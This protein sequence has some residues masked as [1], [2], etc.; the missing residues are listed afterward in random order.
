MHPIPDLAAAL[1]LLTRIPVRAD[2]SRMAAAVWCWPIVGAGIG[3]AA[4][5]AG[6]G[7]TALGAPP[8][9]AAALVL[10][11]SA[12]L[13]GA[14]HED[15]LADLA[16]GLG[17][18]R[19]RA[20]ALEIMTDSR[21]G[22]YGALALILVTLGRWSCIAA[23]D[24]PGVM[25][26]AMLSGALSRAAMGAVMA[27]LPSARPGG[28]SASVGRPPIGA[29]AAGLALAAAAAL[30][31]HPVVGLAAVAGAAGVAVLAKRRLGGQTGDVLG[32]SQQAAEL[33]ALAACAVVLR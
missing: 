19:T 33:C 4:G 5:G 16:D 28:L 27:A 29:T 23:L 11:L 3:A 32:A 14:L 9:L 26:A 2:P 12:L 7:A 10:G 17:G 21:I 13:T 18:G 15:G 30:A 8:G 25:I 20:R 24:G 22:S 1:G 6:W 31:V